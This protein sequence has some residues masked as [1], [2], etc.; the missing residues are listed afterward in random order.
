[1]YTSAL[2]QQK[3]GS[4]KRKREDVGRDTVKVIERKLG[5]VLSKRD[6]KVVELEILEAGDTIQYFVRNNR[7]LATYLQ[8]FICTSYFKVMNTQP[9]RNTC[10]GDASDCWCNLQGGR[11]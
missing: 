9:G 3:I 11:S 5:K 6:H 10:T 1:M 2:E 8:L 7:Q 4:K